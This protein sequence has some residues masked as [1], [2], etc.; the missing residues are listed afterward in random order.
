M[1]RRP[2]PKV[3]GAKVSA[4]LSVECRGSVREPILAPLGWLDAALAR[5]QHGVLD[6][7]VHKVLDKGGWILQPSELREKVLAHFRTRGPEVAEHA[8]RSGRCSMRMTPRRRARPAR[9]SR[10]EASDF[11][12]PIKPRLPRWRVAAGDVRRP[13]GRR[14]FLLEF[15]CFRG[16]GRLGVCSCL[17]LYQYP[18]PPRSNHAQR[19]RRHCVCKACM[20]NSCH[21]F[22][23]AI[24][25]GR[26]KIAV[27][28]RKIAANMFPRFFTR[29]F[30]AE[31]ARDLGRPRTCIFSVPDRDRPAE[32]GS[33]RARKHG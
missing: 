25:L 19:A 20:A 21:R 6:C 27:K 16:D 31:G 10:L 5:P 13:I 14:S 1:E 18:R 23:P 4:R 24:E 26:Q 7:V 2:N 11:A 33:R 28:N 30:F 17:F 32:I 12:S 9:R 8:K 22:A 3:I 15:A 29:D